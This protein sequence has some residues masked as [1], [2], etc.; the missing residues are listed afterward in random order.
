MLHSYRNATFCSTISSIGSSLPLCSDLVLR[1]SQLA[2]KQSILLLSLLHLQNQELLNAYL[3]LVDRLVLL[4]EVHWY[5]PKF[6][7]I[8]HVQISQVNGRGHAVEHL[9]VW[10]HSILIAHSVLVAFAVPWQDEA[11]AA[12]APLVVIGHHY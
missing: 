11:T 4:H 2:T 10:I 8:M 9:G 3:L 6:K 5:L 7:H 1:V 12:I